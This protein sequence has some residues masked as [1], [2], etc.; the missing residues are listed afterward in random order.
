MASRTALPVLPRYR[1]RPY[2][3][4]MLIKLRKSA[5]SWVVKGFLL[6]LALSFAGWGVND[7]FRP[8]PNDPVIV[9]GDREI[10][11]SEFLRAYQQ[12]Y[13]V[14]SNRLGGA[15]TPDQA[16]QFGLVEATTRQIIDSALLDVTARRMRLVVPDSVVVAEIHANPAFHGAG[17]TFDAQLYGQALRGAGLSKEYFE[18][19]S[20]VEAARRQVL[21]SVSSGAAAPR[22]L[23]EAFYR[24]REE[25]RVAEVMVIP[26]SAAGAVETPDETALIAFHRENMA[27][28]MAPEY[29]TVSYV[30]LQPEDLVGEVQVSGEELREEFDA[31]ADEFFEPE[32]RTVEQML[33]ADRATAD[34]AR[35]RLRDG[36][37]F[38]ATAHDLGGLNADDLSLGTIEQRD[39]PT[40]ARAPVFALA[41]GGV[42]DPVQ[43]GFGWHIY[44]VGRIVAGRNP[45]FESMRDRLRTDVALRKAGDSLFEIANALE[46]ELAS[47][48]TLADAAARVDLKPRY[49]EAID[50]TGRDESGALAAAF[51]ADPQF[52]D[53][54]FKAEEGVETSL[55]ETDAGLNF[56]L[57]VERVRPPAARPLEAIRDALTA[58][59]QASRRAEKALELTR[60][61]AAKAGGGTS[62]TDIA[63]ERGLT[64][65]MTAPFSRRGGEDP[66][67]SRD[68]ASGLFAAAIGDVVTAPAGEFEGQIVARLAHV[69]AAPTGA[70]SPELARIDN[71]LRQSIADDLWQQY[72]AHLVADLGVEVDQEAITETF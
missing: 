20:R 14:A 13:R 42:S 53:A 27:R 36:T 10:T 29:R 12:Q 59:W 45:D 54:V 66:A 44:R 11:V 72:R 60:D 71:A 55:I 68:L 32:R 41:E 51:P 57:V 48:A 52:L 56:V 4:L 62:L 67:I 63:A 70:T 25:R 7:I 50:N 49:I 21:T 2:H 9:V 39:L 34:K 31:R 22:A 58:A 64:V 35:A 37:D 61:L 43:T 19:R 16:R 3:H 6:I 33:F 38:V 8:D 26:L 5:G 24:H 30:T 46:D 28:F 47:G 15:L 18:A 65:T 23:S 17:G 1:P 40:E 69:I